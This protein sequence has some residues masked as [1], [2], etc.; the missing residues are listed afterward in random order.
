MRDN[1]YK[2]PLEYS[3]SKALKIYKNRL[4]I[5]SIL[6]L[7]SLSLWM[8]FVFIKTDDPFLVIDML[9]IMLIL[10]FIVKK[11]KKIRNNEEEE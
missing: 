4:R 11:S 2:L 3:L 1:P 6:G 9:Q 10:P 5:L 8:I 7:I